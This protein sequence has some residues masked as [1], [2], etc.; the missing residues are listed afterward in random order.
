[1]S[2]FSCQAILFD[3]DGVLVDS[4]AAI[5]ERWRQWAEYRDVPFEE[6]EAVYHGRPMFEVI[7]HVAPHLDVDAEIDQMSDIMSAA[8]EKLRAFDGAKALLD[9][10]SEAQWT[11]A[12]SGRRRT[13]TNRLSH[14]GLPT[15]DTLVTADDVEHG[16]PHPESYLLAAERLGIAPEH[17][18][19]FEDAPAGIEAGQ[20][21]GARVIGVAS[22]IAPDA[23]STAD[24]VIHSIGDVEVEIE[25][26]DTL[27][28]H[29]PNDL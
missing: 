12:T 28:V 25:S 8:P 3:L 22:T 13:A 7:Q 26:D 29:C 2:S 19:V 10:L 9:R 1:M 11:I 18:V 17:C 21:A 27:S 20:R 4:E 15:P 5:E 23:L 24:A 14:V 6:V 16:K